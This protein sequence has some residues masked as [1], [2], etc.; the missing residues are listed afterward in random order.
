MFKHFVHSQLLTFFLS[1]NRCE[2][3]MTKNYAWK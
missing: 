2:T 1:T 3:Q